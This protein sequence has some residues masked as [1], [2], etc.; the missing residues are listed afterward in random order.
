MKFFSQVRS[1]T[2]G[3]AL[4]GKKNFR[5]FIIPERGTQ[6]QKERQRTNPDRSRL[7]KFRPREPGC[8]VG[9]KFVF[10]PECLPEL[11]VPDL[12]GFELKPYVSYK[13]KD[14]VQ[15]EFTPQ[16]LFMAVYSKK[17]SEDLKNG[18]LD[19]DYNPKEPSPEE[20]LTPEEAWTKARQ[21]G[22]DI[23]AMR[24]KRE[25]EELYDPDYLPHNCY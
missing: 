11:V 5:K 23:F 7:Y 19:D 16:D 6:I 9:E 18:K 15:S 21:T 20:L 22:S 24:S 14:V 25:E 2:T 4:L 13:V 1:F 3:T 12:T 10:I 8:Y 17:I